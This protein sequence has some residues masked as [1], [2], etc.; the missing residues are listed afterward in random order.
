MLYWLFKRGRTRRRPWSTSQMS[1]GHLG[2]AEVLWQ[3]INVHNQDNSYH[4]L[5][6][7]LH[8][9]SGNFF[10]SF[11]PPLPQSI[12]LSSLPLSFIYI[13]SGKF[14]K[15]TDCKS[16]TSVNKLRSWIF[17]PPS[18]NHIF[19][20]CRFSTVDISWNKIKSGHS[21]QSSWTKRVM[22]RNASSVTSFTGGFIFSLRCE[23]EPHFQTVCVLL[24]YHALLTDINLVLYS[25]SP[26]RMWKFPGWL[27]LDPLT[28][29]RS[30]WWTKRPHWNWRWQDSKD[31]VF[32]GDQGRFRWERDDLFHETNSRCAG[33]EMFM[34]VIVYRK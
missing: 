32:G 8:N 20:T 13:Y 26:S 4:H 31:A 17:L 28:Q 12:E 22:I 9:G 7:Q 10:P 5:V 15:L 29:L 6:N 30:I 21:F 11:P 23:P 34:N 2:Y 18:T 16:I 27:H 24:T 1:E 14:K 3:E 19:S 33:L 25:L